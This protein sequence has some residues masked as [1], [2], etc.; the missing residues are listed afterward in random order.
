MLASASSARSP[1]KRTRSEEFSG[2]DRSRRS[3]DTVSKVPSV[4]GMG[5]SED[6][7]DGGPE[8]G[9]ETSIARSRLLRLVAYAA[10][11]VLSTVIVNEAHAQQS[12]PP[13]RC[14]PPIPP[15]PDEC[16]PF[17]CPPVT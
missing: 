8:S 3:S 1:R 6:P 12:C 13:S 15:P 9:D 16:P 7:D 10:P 4:S 2:S 14:A 17:L 11:M 5:S